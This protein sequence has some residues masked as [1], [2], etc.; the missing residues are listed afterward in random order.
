[1][2]TTTGLLTYEVIII[3]DHLYISFII[4]CVRINDLINLKPI[5]MFKNITL[6]SALLL[7][8]SFVSNAGILNLDPKNVVDT[9]KVPSITITP[10]KP[11]I[12][13]DLYG[14]Y[15][16][17]DIIIKNQTNHV[18]ELSSIEAA[19]MD[20]SG[21]FIL[22]KAMNWEGRSPGIDLLG[23]T[24]IKP[25][26]TI[27]IFNPFHTFQPDITIG[28]LKYGLFFNYADNPVQKENN[29][30]RL[31]IDF[32]ASSVLLVKPKIYIA[33]NEYYLP[34][35]GKLVV[36][37]GHDFYSRNRRSPIEITDNK[38][39]KNNNESRYAYDLMSV[40]ADGNMYYD[41]P[42]KKQNWFVFGK[43]VNAPADGRVVFIKNDIPDNE[44]K[45]KAVI[46]PK[47]SATTD[48]QG[49]GNYIVIKHANGEYTELLN[50]EKGSIN[51]KPGSMVKAGQQLAIVGFSGN[52]K[53]PHLHYS[54]TNG[55]KETASEGLPNY[56]NDYKLYRGENIVKVSRSRIDSG[57]IV[58]SSR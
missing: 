23:V 29:K 5:F 35:K 33:K 20:G 34:L 42:F 50:L 46:L 26:Q 54:V 28:S 9:T 11:L 3:I 39:A 12:E 36:W 32:D 38:P 58:E 43:P 18:L 14:Y 6:I 51:V 31:P 4:I 45:D 19:I 2:V 52:A 47:L 48:P 55:T 30:K 1:M 16:N 40:D 22:R 25:G 21:K 8:N 57:D 49:K 7:L 37:D 41:T 27:S 15:L 24:E 53:Y 17:F 44:Y 10:G 13:K 56:F